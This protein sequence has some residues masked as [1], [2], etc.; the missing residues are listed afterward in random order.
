MAPST[1]RVPDLGHARSR[2]GPLTPP[3]DPGSADVSP[4]AILDG[5]QHVVTRGV[6][7]VLVEDLDL[8]VAGVPGGGDP[9]ADRGEVHV[10]VTHV[11]AGEQ[12]IGGQR[13]V[14]VAHL[15]RGDPVFG[16][17]PGDLVLQVGVPPH[18]VGVDHDAD[19]LGRERRSEI[20]RLAQRR[21][22]RAVRGEHRVQRFERDAHAVGGRERDQVGDAVGVVVDTYHV[23]WD[24]DLQHQIARAGS[25]RRIASYQV[26]DWNL[27]LTADPPV[28]RGYMGD[29]Y[30]DFASIGGWITSA[31]Y[32]GDVEV[33][34]F[35]QQVWDTPGDDVLTTVEDRYRRYV[36]PSLGRPAG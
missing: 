35:N 12:R 2:A 21:D 23:W 31:G 16:P 14:P 20:E 32:T 30:V 25:E 33:E 17:R 18:V 3:V 28:S 10:A 19:R 15:V 8:D 36:L 29:G 26:C 4:V 13:E 34:I 7:D 5:R 1:D 22:D 24:P 11:P 6:P 27:P 9:A